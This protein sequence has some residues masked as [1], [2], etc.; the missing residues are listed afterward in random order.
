M[1]KKYK[2]KVG[3]R[4]QVMHGNAKIT[5]GGLTKRQLKY[6][7]QGKI[8]SKKAS[9]SAKKSNNLVKAGYITKKG[10]FG[11][12]KKGGSVN[13]SNKYGRKSTKHRLYT[14]LSDI[15]SKQNINITS[16]DLSGK[17]LSGN[18]P[19]EILKLSKLKEL[20]LSNNR[21]TGRIP[22]EIF[23]LENLVKLNL[24]NNR[25]TEILS[26]HIGKLKYLKE[27]NLS[28]NKLI[29]IG[30]LIFPVSITKINLSNNKL[31]ENIDIIFEKP[32]D[33]N[34]KNTPHVALN[35]S[36]NN[37]TEIE[38]GYYDHYSKIFIKVNKL[39]LSNNKRFKID[40]EDIMN[41]FSNMDSL[42]ELKIENTD[43]S[44]LE[45][46]KDLLIAY[47]NKPNEFKSKLKIDIIDIN[48][49]LSERHK[50]YPNISEVYNNHKYNIYISD[51][52]G[53]IITNEYFF[54]PKNLSIILLTTPGYKTWS[55]IISDNIFT[56]IN[57]SFKVLFPGKLYGYKGQKN[58][59][60]FFR[61]GDIINNI[62]FN[63]KLDYNINNK[64]TYNSGIYRLYNKNGIKRHISNKKKK[65]EKAYLK[66]HIK[67]NNN[68][69]SW[70]EITETN[71]Y[72]HTLNDITKKFIKY[73]NNKY[74]L[75]V[76]SCLTGNSLSE[77]RRNS[78]LYKFKEELRTKL[79]CFQDIS[80]RLDEDEK[81][82]R[83]RLQNM[84]STLITSKYTKSCY[85]EILQRIGKDNRL[86]N[87]LES[88]INNCEIFDNSFMELI[89]HLLESVKQMVEHSKHNK[90]KNKNKTISNKE[91]FNI[92]GINNTSNFNKIKKA[93]FKKLRSIHPNKVR[94]KV[95]RNNKEYTE[96][97]LKIKPWFNKLR[98][99]KKLKSNIKSINN[100]RKSWLENYK[101]R[102]NNLNINI[103]NYNK[104]NNK[105]KK[106][107]LV[108]QLEYIIK[109][110]KELAKVLNW[111]NIY[112]I[113]NI[114]INK[115]NNEY[116]LDFILNDYMKY[117]NDN[118]LIKEIKGLIENIKLPSLTRN[119]EL[120]NNSIGK[121]N[122]LG[123][124]NNLELLI[125]DNNRIV[126]FN[127][128]NLP[129]S[130]SNIILDNNYILDLIGIKKLD[131]LVNLS[132]NHNYIYDLSGIESLNRLKILKLNNNQISDL[133]GIRFPNSIEKL[134]LDNNQISDLNGI[135]LP[136]NLVYL[137]LE[138]NNIDDKGIEN[139]IFPE[140][141]R[142]INLKNN[143]ITE[144]MKQELY[145]KYGNNIIL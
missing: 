18:I 74:I 139:I 130:I 105:N 17:S 84:S 51:S 14:Q 63:Y 128:I 94:S 77:V 72:N 15:I 136:E 81:V 115:E 83:K 45:L 39:N 117:I 138:N 78:I 11:T 132:L 110:N 19:S 111:T 121:L 58:N 4:A 123:S 27:V 135:K 69:P 90:N 3:S 124:L 65:N 71:Y 70:P 93:Y 32:F 41:I 91:A 73:K 119:I 38:R 29:D 122:N 108:N 33:F 126:Q 12:I 133:S 140:N 22:L 26:L 59:I 129:N 55:N 23:K 103:K 57:N 98:K 53:S 131:K 54:V 1:V 137:S 95:N 82:G 7:K 86:N 10:V 87:I 116:Y 44:E 13:F 144:Y 48:K 80:I 68:G 118:S 46:T 37:I 60:R 24:S 40:T 109:N 9:K 141:I 31:S 75:V 142:E 96:I 30:P 2:Q 56:Q 101:S 43:L 76:I 100:K 42:E 99:N 143:N 66:D 88:Y 5:G 145:I 92:L 127:D 36:N 67:E 28:N 61:P 113:K 97:F 104:L 89:L 64:Y 21:L 52:H 25:L 134:H 34:Y 120:Y 106:K 50:I 79:Q 6:N 62:Y 20:N 102:K 112:N 85:Y 114:K 107:I 35:L 49:I 16:L 8:V 125:I 47:Y